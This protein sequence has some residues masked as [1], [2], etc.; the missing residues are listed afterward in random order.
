MA[1]QRDGQTAEIKFLYYTLL[2][3]EYLPRLR[4]DQDLRIQERF[5]ALPPN[6]PAFEEIIYQ[7]DTTMGRGLAKT[8]PGRQSC[9]PIIRPLITG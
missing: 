2:Y 5:A 3:I 1:D 8:R 7:S 6:L 9:F 4:E